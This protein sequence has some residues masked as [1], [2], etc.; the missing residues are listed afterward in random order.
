MEILDQFGINSFLLFAQIV[1][2][3]VLLFI[4]KR[5]LYGPILR[6]LESRKKTVEQSLKNADEIE[7]K[8]AIL[9]EKKEET[10]NVAL[11]EAEKIVQEAKSHG[12]QIIEESK[13]QAE[14]IVTNALVEAKELIRQ[15]KDKLV[16]EVRENVASLFGL[17]LQKVLGKAL[18]GK[19]QKDL[20]EQSL[21]QLK[22]EL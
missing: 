7:K 9:E 8:L 19:D 12:K 20:I 3:A 16:G 17:F 21:K 4:L 15:E 13:N 22:N 11:A 6:V 1:N 2:F 14:R 5:F 10:I 18:T